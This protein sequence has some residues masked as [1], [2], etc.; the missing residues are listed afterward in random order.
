MI[1]T[2]KNNNKVLLKGGTKSAKNIKTNYENKNK[3][4]L[5]I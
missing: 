2:N 3:Y 5:Y 4:H 1:Q